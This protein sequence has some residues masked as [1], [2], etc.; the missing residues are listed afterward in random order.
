MNL[1]IYHP[2]R[3]VTYSGKL[4]KSVQNKHTDINTNSILQYLF[5]KGYSLIFALLIFVPLFSKP[6]LAQ[7]SIN[8]DIH[9]REWTLIQTVDQVKFYYQTSLCNGHSFL[10][11]RIVNGN[12]S[13]VHGSW[14]MDVQSNSQ[15]RKCMGVLLPTMP[16]QS[17]VGSCANPDPD[18]V[19]PFTNLE[20]A[21][22]RISLEAKIT[23]H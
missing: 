8:K 1:F 16:G 22:L 21:T 4:T 14:Q 10:L 20:L 18:M 7:T 17:R 12:A 6:V 5:G 13:S 3:H 9:N 19:I 2:G 23:L 15:K 11:L